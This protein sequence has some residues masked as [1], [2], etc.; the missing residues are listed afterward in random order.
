MNKKTP[1]IF[2]KISLKNEFHIFQKQK[3]IKK[4]K[5][6]TTILTHHTKKNVY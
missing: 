6:V 3:L 5:Q 4:D 2:I 1:F